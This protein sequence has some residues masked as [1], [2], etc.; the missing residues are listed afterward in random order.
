MCRRNLIVLLTS[1]I[2]ALSFS[3]GAFAEQ[4]T[5]WV[6]RD[7]N[8]YYY[9]ASGVQAKNQWLKSGEDLF[10]MQEDGSMAT[11]AWLERDEQWYYMGASGAAVS[12]W[13]EINGKYY[14]FSKTTYVM[15]TNVTID[16]W[17]V[18]S[19]GAWDPSK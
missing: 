9:S 8:W 16:S 14:F 1:L 17:Y 19:D 15:A 11:N 4:Q 12:G 6:S 7:G 13:Q 2:L 18:G 5:G 3:F 10:W